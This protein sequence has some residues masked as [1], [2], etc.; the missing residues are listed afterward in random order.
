[1][2]SDQLKKRHQVVMSQKRGFI[3]FE[4]T[5]TRFGHINMKISYILFK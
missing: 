2:T 5:F 4:N 3:Y 1:M